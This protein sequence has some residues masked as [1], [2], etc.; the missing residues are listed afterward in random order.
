MEA[1]VVRL[2]KY[3]EDRVA[4]NSF[5]SVVQFVVP[6]LLLLGLTPVFIHQMGTENYGLWMLATSALGLMSIAEFGLNTAVSKFVAEYVSSEDTNALSVV[7]SSGLIAYI[8]LGVGLIIPLYIYSPA[9]AGILQPSE[10]LSA[11]QIECGYP[12][13]V[14]GIYSSF[15]A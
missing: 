12:D 7:V 4:R 3:K 1:L 6:T 2:R 5:Y 11:E 14:F 13:Y 15:I 8:L 9:L 10:S